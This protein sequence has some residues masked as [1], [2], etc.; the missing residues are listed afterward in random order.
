MRLSGVPPG[1]YPYSGDHNLFIINGS[2]S[3]GISLKLWICSE[4]NAISRI[5][6][7]TKIYPIIPTLWGYYKSY[8]ANKRVTRVFAKKLAE[9][10][11][12]VLIPDIKKAAMV[13]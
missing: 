7:K 6:A 1:N 12:E 9:L 5:L 4:A 3:G 8:R 2:Q 13:F 11:Y 10:G